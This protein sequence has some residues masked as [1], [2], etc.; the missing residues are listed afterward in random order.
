[1]SWLIGLLSISLLAL[2]LWDAFETIILPRRVTRRF[3]LTRTFYQYV[4]LPWF[5]IA[6]QMTPGRRQEGFLSVF[7]PLSV[8]LLFSVWAVGL[9]LS[10]AMLQWATGRILDGVWSVQ[11]FRTEL[12]LSGTTFF[13]LGL[14]DVT[15]QTPVTRLVTVVEAGTG[16]GFLAIVIAYLPV[17]YGAF[18]RREVN[19]SL[20]DARAG[21]PPTAAELLRRHTRQQNLEALEH[22][23]RAWETWAAELMESHLSYPVLCYFRSQ[24]NNQSW[25]SALATILDSCALLIAHTE[26]ALRWQ[27]DLTFA[28]SRHALVDLAQVLGI[29]PQPPSVDRFDPVILTELRVI[30]GAAGAPLCKTRAAEETL[31]Q[32]R[33]MYEPFL[34]GFSELLLM[35]LPAWGTGTA[36]VDNWRTS[37]WGRVSTTAGFAPDPRVEDDEHA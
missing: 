24:H 28:I 33:Q 11:S 2:I 12:Y 20:L 35:P 13:T 14:G 3:R 5:L 29:P 22:Y 16:F 34:F 27:A 8:L 26:G 19:I 18:S 37:A 36:I 4:R 9:I 1:M 32:L 30:L 25:V 21:S 10:F 6:R 23:L 15:P 31:K 7:G 17:L